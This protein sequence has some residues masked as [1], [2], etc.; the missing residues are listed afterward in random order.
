MNPE[1]QNNDKK[2][3]KCPPDLLIDGGIAV[4]ATEIGHHPAG[5]SPHNTTT[6][7]KHQLEDILKM[8]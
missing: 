4:V 8:L 5:K 3:Q 7:R 1:I 6:T 2:H